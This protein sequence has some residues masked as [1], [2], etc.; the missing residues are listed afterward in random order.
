MDRPVHRR[1]LCGAFRRD[2]DAPVHGFRP[3]VAIE[4]GSVDGAVDGVRFEAGALRHVNLPL[5][6]DVVVVGLRVVDAIGVA[7]AAAQRTKIRQGKL[8]TR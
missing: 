6:A 2:R 3:H 5:D 4:A 1:R 7:I 8:E